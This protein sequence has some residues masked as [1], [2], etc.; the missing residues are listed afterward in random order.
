MSYIV[1]DEEATELNEFCFDFGHVDV[2]RG[3]DRF[4]SGYQEV[5][6]K[7]YNS[8]T[9]WDLSESLEKND[10][11][12][13]NAD[14]FGLTYYSPDSETKIYLNEDPIVRSEMCVL[15]VLRGGLTE[16]QLPVAEQEVIAL[17]YELTPE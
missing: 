16:S 7:G 8:R 12:L 14:P 1:A 10:Y 13:M 6:L 4:R 17:F 5:C 15:T 11:R 3:P 9:L 2:K